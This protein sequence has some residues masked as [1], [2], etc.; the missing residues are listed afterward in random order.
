[1]PEFVLKT[2]DRIYCIGRFCYDADAAASQPIH[3]QI[4]VDELQITYDFNDCYRIVMNTRIKILF[5]SLLGGILWVFLLSILIPATD[6][7][8]FAGDL[9]LDRNTE[10]FPY[11]FTIQNLMW[12]VFSIGVGELIV[13]WRVGL[14]EQAQL[15]RNLLPEDRETIWE[16]KDIGAVNRGILVSDSVHKMWLQRLCSRCLLAFQ[17]S[18]SIAQVNAIFNSTMDLYQ[19]EIDLR[20]N[21][22]KYLVWLIPTLGFIGTVVGIALALSGAGELVAKGVDEGALLTELGPQLMQQLTK[23]LGVAF[24]TTLLAL[25]QSAVLMFAMHLVQGR[26]EETL[27]QIG[28]YCLDNL[29]NRLTE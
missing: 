10:S 19:N 4:I 17:S 12:L 23:Q 14:Q 27:N 7:G 15:T 28:Q 25:L 3:L 29:I 16:L 1:M 8:N 11:P 18:V 6:G 22:L 13:R 20:Y 2:T 24:Y 5:I 26:E 9:L 21:M